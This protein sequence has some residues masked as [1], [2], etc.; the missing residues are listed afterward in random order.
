MTEPR[1]FPP[2]VLARLAPQQYLSRFLEKDLRPCGRGLGEMRQMEVQQGNKELIKGALGSAVVR[3]GETTVICGILGGFTD[4]AKEGGVYP[5][6][7]IHRMGRT[8]IP[9]VEEM[10]LTQK[11]Q[12]LIDAA[13]IPRTNFKI[14]VSDTLH[15]SRQELALRANIQVLSRSGPCLDACWAALVAALEDTSIPPFA[16]DEKTL[17]TE[18]TEGEGR[19]LELPVT[20]ATQSYNIGLVEGKTLADIDGPTEESCVPNVLNAFVTE[21]DSF[22]G[23]S[24]YAP[25]ESFTVEQLKQ[26]LSARR[27]QL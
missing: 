22:A 15:D 5:N 12:E 19:P 14:D 16:M 13:Q 3:C 7:K 11:L 25:T 20:L 10:C 6:V 18:P 27:Q 23:I 4:L 2:D 24:I 8:G 1:S 26:A 9:T 17:K 21:N